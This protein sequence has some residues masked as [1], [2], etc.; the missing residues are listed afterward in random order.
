MQ[1]LIILSLLLLSSLS[2]RS[3]EVV[4]KVEVSTDTVLMDNYFE[5]KFTLENT[6]ASFSPPSFSEFDIVG[7]PQQSSSFTMINGVVTQS[8]TYTYYLKPRSEGVFFIDS[9]EIEVDGE[10]LKTPGVEIIVLPNPEGI[11]ENPHQLRKGRD[12]PKLESP[13]PQK[14]SPQKIIWL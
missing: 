13:S 5:V 6:S 14:T 12:I 3:E 1:S 8:A 2:L 10:A 4:F 9:A 7:G 11:I